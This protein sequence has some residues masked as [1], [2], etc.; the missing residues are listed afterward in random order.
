MSK[1]IATREYGGVDIAEKIRDVILDVNHTA[2]DAKTELLLYIAGPSP[3]LGLKILQTLRK[4]L[5]SWLIDLSIV[6]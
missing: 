1:I 5:L 4:M 3:T 6:H 2:M